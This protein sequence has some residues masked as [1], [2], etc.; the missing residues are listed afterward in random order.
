[1]QMGDPLCHEPVNILD[2]VYVVDVGFNIFAA[3]INAVCRMLGALMCERESLLNPCTDSERQVA[4]QLATRSGP[5]RMIGRLDSRTYALGR[6]QP[7]VC[8]AFTSSVNAH[9][10]LEKVYVR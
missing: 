10:G 9:K 2:V 1:M 4:S 7:G 8:L 3:C 6:L 5:Q